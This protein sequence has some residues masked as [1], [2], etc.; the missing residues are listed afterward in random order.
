MSP[1]EEGK[2]VGV[3]DK[4][5]LSFICRKSGE[6]QGSRLGIHRYRYAF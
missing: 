3:V 4:V 2:M 5:G 6:G 1:S